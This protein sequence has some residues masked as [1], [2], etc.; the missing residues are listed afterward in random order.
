MGKVSVQPATMADAIEMGGALAWKHAASIFAVEAAPATEIIVETFEKSTFSRAGRLDDRLM[1]LWGVV[2]LNVVTGVASPWLFGSAHLARVPRLTCLIAR[3]A[4]R[5][6]LD[7]FPH[8]FGML[9][10]SYE[11]SVRFAR[12]LGFT[13]GPSERPPLLK[14]EMVKT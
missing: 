1:A 8:L 12:H 3:E 4:I 11:A 7:A 10:P 9:D 13:V 2:P 14:I 6:M 5:E